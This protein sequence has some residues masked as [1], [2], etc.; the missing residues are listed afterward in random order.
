MSTVAPAP[1]I[2][3]G[4]AGVQQAPSLDEN[5][6]LELELEHTLW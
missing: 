3:Q 2:C 6:D 5:H 1:E 4:L